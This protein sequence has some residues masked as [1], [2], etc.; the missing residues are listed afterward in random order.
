MKERDP[1]TDP[2]PGDVLQ[3]SLRQNRYRITYRVHTVSGRARHNNSGPGYV[4]VANDSDDN[5]DR[6]SFCGTQWRR[7]AATAEVVTRAEEKQNA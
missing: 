4:G 7:W 6:L 5:L 1:R 2:M 3:K